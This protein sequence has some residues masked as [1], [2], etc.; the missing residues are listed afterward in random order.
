MQGPI[1]PRMPSRKQAQADT[2]K[3]DGV[4][5]GYFLLWY[6]N[7]QMRKGLSSQSVKRIFKHMKQRQQIMQAYK[8]V[9]IQAEVEDSR[10]H[11]KQHS[12]P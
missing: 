12:Y 5:T 6:V 8:E 3:K 1:S 2:V 4:C 9:E 11:C 7:I 10:V